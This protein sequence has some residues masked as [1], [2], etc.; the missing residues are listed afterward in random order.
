MRSAITDVLPAPAPA[1]R[2]SGV[3]G[4]V[5]ASRCSGVG[6]NGRSGIDRRL[7]ARG[8]DRAQSVEGTHAAIG[9]YR[10]LELL[11]QDV[12]GNGEHSCFGRG[13][14]VGR[15]LLR[16]DLHAPEEHEVE[17]LGRPARGQFRIARSSQ[18]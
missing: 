12:V 13:F 10:G 11:G 2:N 8:L 14:V 3:S 17:L 15:D 9:L 5:I 4:W 1:T 6:V 18:V 16:A 7:S